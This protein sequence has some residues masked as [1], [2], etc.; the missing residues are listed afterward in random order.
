MLKPLISSSRFLESS[1]SLAPWTYHVQARDIDNRRFGTFNDKT[2][3]F[4]QYRRALILETLVDL[5][6]DTLP[7]ATA[8]DLA[9]NCGVFALEAVRLGFKD[10]RGLDIRPENI[11]Q[12]EFLKLAF[13][14]ENCIFEV[15]NVKELAGKPCDVVLLLGIMYHLST[16]FEVMRRAFEVT[17]KICVVD[18]ITHKEPVSAY[19]VQA[20]DTARVLEGDQTFELQPSYRGIIDTMKIA[21]FETIIEVVGQADQEIDLYS[22]NSRRCLLGIRDKTIADRALGW[23]Q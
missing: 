14:V 1:A 19:F 6:G 12:A 11:R 9:C 13:G 18:T 16:P 10:V 20:K 7:A 8:L 5:L 23:C 22:D 17:G 3:A 4:H 2:V 21:G 15:G